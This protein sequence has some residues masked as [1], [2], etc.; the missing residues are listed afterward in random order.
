MRT[1]LAGLALLTGVSLAVEG[2]PAV[3]QP[4]ESVALTFDDLPA[5]GPLP[6]GETRLSVV[7]AILR[8]LKQASVKEA[9]GFVA[10]S[11]GSDD[12]QSPLVLK[13][14]RAAGYPLGNH[15][16]SH[17]NLNGVSADWYMEDIARNDAVIEPL[18]KGRDWR[19]FRYPYLAEGEDLA[20]RD[21][22]RT[23]LAQRSYRV[24]AVTINF[25]DHAYN[26][27]YVRCRAAADTAGVARL[28]VL[29][30]TGA[31]ATL[32]AAR[33]AG[34]GQIMLLHVGTFTAHMLPWLLA[35]YRHSG[36]RF[37][38]LARATELLDAPRASFPAY[39]T[40]FAELAA[41]CPNAG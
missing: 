25:D 24:A 15:S 5:H 19:W 11:F 18:M 26:A 35:Q 21:A 17:A 4:P 7:R 2:A 22:V 32:G 16:W 23:G 20:K 34:G 27:P 28:E 14:W 40:P 41:L 38:S 29:Y 9:Y 31:V 12:P 8:A 39:A 10:G 13:A 1:W 33:Q 6:P 3:A 37:V 36:A 30:R